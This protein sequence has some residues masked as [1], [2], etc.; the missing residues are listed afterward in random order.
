MTTPRLSPAEAVA[1]LTPERWAQATRLL[2]RKALAE[3]THERLADEQAGGLC[4]ALGGE[5]GYGLGG[6][7]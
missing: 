7:E 6:G 4:P 5:V 2:V 1:H 3:F